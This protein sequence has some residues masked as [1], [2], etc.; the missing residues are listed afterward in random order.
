MTLL[1]AKSTKTDLYEHAK[2][3]LGLELP[4]YESITKTELWQLIEL[5]GANGGSPLESSEPQKGEPSGYVIKSLRARGNVR[6]NR[7][8]LGPGESMHLTAEVVA[9]T[10][11]LKDKLEY[12]AELKMW[13]ITR[14]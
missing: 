3:D 8:P 14:G 7:E 6:V 5:A 4:D 1:N 9:L 13:S 10:P 12:G 2:T 11:N